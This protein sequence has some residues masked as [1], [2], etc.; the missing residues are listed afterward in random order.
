M[1]IY[2]VYIKEEYEKD[3]NLGYYVNEGD[4]I[5]CKHETRSY[6]GEIKVEEIEVQEDF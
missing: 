6:C 3:R 4:A 2:R 1:T 5:T